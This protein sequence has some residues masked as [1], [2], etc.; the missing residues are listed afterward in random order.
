MFK[1]KSLLLAATFLLASATSFGIANHSKSTNSKK[2][3][4]AVMQKIPLLTYTE[5]YYNKVFVNGFSSKLFSFAESPSKEMFQSIGAGSRYLVIHPYVL[6]STGNELKV[7]SSKGGFSADPFEFNFVSMDFDSNKEL[8]EIFPVQK[9]LQISSSQEK[10]NS[11]DADQSQII[12][13]QFDWKDAKNYS[14]TKSSVIENDPKHFE[15]LKSAV[16]KIWDQ[17][18]QM[19]GKP[20]DQKWIDSVSKETA[21]FIQAS[22]QSGGHYSA[23]KDLAFVASHLRLEKDLSPEEYVK[24]AEATYEAFQKKHANGKYHDGPSA[25]TYTKTADGKLPSRVRLVPLSDMKN[26][27]MELMGDGRLAR[28]TNA[29]GPVISFISNYNDG[30]RNQ[31]NEKRFEVDLWFRLNAKQ[32][33]Q[34]DAVYPSSRISAYGPSLWPQQVMKA[35]PY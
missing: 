31:P 18:D 22:Q 20:T 2:K 17:L 3:G 29:A 11:A 35:L 5:I 33:W 16:Q 4:A 24:Q 14:W 32:E 9:L 19:T 23:I 1:Q 12:T 30:S 28:L 15:T 26:L 10:K 13:G 25:P 7:Q 21:E 34:L 27:K 8:G 6:K